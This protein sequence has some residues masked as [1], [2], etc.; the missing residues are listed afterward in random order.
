MN[1]IEPSVRTSGEEG[2]KASCVCS[3]PEGTATIEPNRDVPLAPDQLIPRY[4]DRAAINE[5]QQTST[6]KSRHVSECNLNAESEELVDLSLSHPK[7]YFPWNRLLKELQ[8]KV[9]RHLTRSDLDKC[10]VLN[11]ETFQLIRRNEESMK[12][13]IIEYLQIRIYYTKKSRSFRL[14]IFVRCAEVGITRNRDLSVLNPELW[15]TPNTFE[16]AVQHLRESF[17]P[18]VFRNLSKLLKNATIQHMEIGTG[19]LTNNILWPITS[20]FLNVDCRV[21]KLSIGEA[22]AADVTSPVFLEFLRN[23]APT[24][25]E[26]YG[27][28]DCSHENFSPEVLEFIVTRPKFELRSLG[29]VPFPL[30]DDILA[31]LTASEFT[32]DAETRITVDGIKSFV[33][34]LASGKHE[35]IRGRIRIHISSGSLPFSTPPSI[36]VFYDGSILTLWHVTP[37]KLQQSKE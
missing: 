9:L 35:L 12:R 30:D 7:D 3:S 34:V 33:G 6:E 13:R 5:N 20:C 11:R 2:E 1:D 17:S 31:K 29:P 10:R 19:Q 27:I 4:S 16:D 22:S 26:F 25:I 24:H 37:I 8:V 18:W 15:R 36:K 21:Q 28:S 32:I 14:E 23:A